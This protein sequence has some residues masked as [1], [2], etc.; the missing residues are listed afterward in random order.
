MTV[1]NRVIIPYYIGLVN[2]LVS[3]CIKKVAPVPSQNPFLGS[4][5]LVVVAV[6][7]MIATVTMLLLV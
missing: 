7:K 2:L 1:R 6:Q 3:Y 4:L 5:S